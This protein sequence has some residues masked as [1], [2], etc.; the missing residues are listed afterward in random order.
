M[1][2]RAN[3][4]RSPLTISLAAA[5]LLLLNIGI[6]LPMTSA[7]AT[8]TSRSS[9][10]S[11]T[12]GAPVGTMFGRWI[13][14]GN[15]ARLQFG[16]GHEIGRRTQADGGWFTPWVCGRGIT[17]L[18]SSHEVAAENDDGRSIRFRESVRFRRMGG[19]WSAWLSFTTFLKRK[20]GLAVGTF[21]RQL[22][23]R[24]ASCWKFQWTLQVLVRAPAKLSG[25]YDLKVSNSDS[26][27]RYSE[28]P[29][30]VNLC[31]LDRD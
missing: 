25:Y 4:Q 20:E 27:S 29:E 15:D 21:S 23:A 22:E 2:R 28:R 18:E 11:R 19:K 10:R 16:G 12:R 30:R 14:H 9:F 1:F 6:Y 24:R 8:V 26:G 7:A 31:L 17:K 3:R 5:S 13:S